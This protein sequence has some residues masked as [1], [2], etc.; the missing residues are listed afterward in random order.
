MHIT[1][2]NSFAS[3][4]MLEQQETVVHETGHAVGL[5]H[6]ENVNVNNSV[7]RASG[8]NGKAYPLYDDKYGIWYIY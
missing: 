3:A 1:F 7:M 8:F 5:S 6:T 4:T 2:Y